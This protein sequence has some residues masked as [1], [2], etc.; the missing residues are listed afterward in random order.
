MRNV[1]PQSILLLFLLTAGLFQAGCTIGSIGLIDP[2]FPQG[3]LRCEITG[4]P[5]FSHF[6][7]NDYVWIYGIV[8][9]EGADV[10][11]YPFDGPLWHVDSGTINPDYY[12]F[13]S[14]YDVV[15]VR[16]PFD[17]SFFG[18][19]KHTV[20]LTAQDYGDSFSGRA[21]DSITLIIDD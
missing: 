3:N 14:L 7:Y 13:D 5:T 11:S 10:E 19:G 12:I 8:Y 18:P 21:S 2:G 16:F 17:A 4:P 20:T 6:H 1:I 15:E 9:R